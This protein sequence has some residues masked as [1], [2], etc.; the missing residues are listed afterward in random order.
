LD[1]LLVLILANATPIVIWHGLGQSCCD[2]NGIGRV[3]TILEKV[4]KAYVYSVKIGETWLEDTVNG[5]F[6]PAKEQVNVYKLTLN[7]FC[8]SF[9]CSTGKRMLPRSH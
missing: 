4:T 8:H 2:P 5:F 1:L 7:Y 9:R 3:K 6:M